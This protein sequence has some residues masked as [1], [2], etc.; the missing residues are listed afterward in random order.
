MQIKAQ[1][2]EVGCG[3]KGRGKKT[4]TNGKCL[5]KLPQAKGAKGHGR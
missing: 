3:G 5:K 4:Q 2:K 1:E